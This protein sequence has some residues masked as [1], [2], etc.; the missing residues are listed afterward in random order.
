MFKAFYYSFPVQLFLNNL[1]KNQILLLFWVLLFAVVTE[2]FGNVLGVPY[3]FLDPEYMN[4]VDFWSFFIVGISLGV[5][6]MGFH[7]TCYILDGPK[8]NFLGTLRRPFT[9]FTINNSIIPIAFLITYIIAIINFQIE[10]EFVTFDLLIEKISGLIAGFLVM[11]VFL[12]AYF[13]FTNKD[14]FKILAANVDKSLKKVKVTRVNVMQRLDSAKKKSIRVDNFIDHNFQIR[15]NRGDLKFYNK[16]EIVKVFD[17]N[18][19]NSVIIEFLLFALI[20]SLGIFREQALFQIPAAASSILLLAFIIMFTGAISFWV[21]GWTITAVIALVFFINF[22][23]QSDYFNRTFEAY[24]LNY[25]TVKSIYTVKELQAIN[26]PEVFERD[27]ESTIEILNNW[28]NN[29]PEDKKPKMILIGTSGGGQRAALWTMRTLQFADSASNGSLLNNTILISGASGGLIGAAYYRELV[30]RKKQGE[31]IDLTHSKYLDN[32]ARDNLN[33]IIF[34]LLVND[35]FIRYQNFEFNGR[36]YAKDRGYAF[37][38]QLNK[39]TEFYL[40]KKLGDYKEPERQGL[41]PM[42][43]LAPNIIND[44]RKLY[45]S[46]QNTSYMNMAV[47]DQ[48]SNISPKIKAIDFSRYFQAQGAENLRFISALRMSATFPYVTPNIALPSEPKMQIM[49]AGIADNFGI[50]DAVRFL[51][52]FKDWINENTSGVIMISIRDSEKEQPIEKIP[53]KSLFEKI[54]NPIRSLYINFDNIQ[55]IN[56]DNLLEYADALTN[57]NIT[58]IN[59]E[60]IPKDIPEPTKSERGSSD[61]VIEREIERASLSW[62]LTGLEKNN[63]KRSIY[64]VNN[65]TALRRLLKE[66]EE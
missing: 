29:F 63:I 1:K 10:N 45:I 11:L 55:D 8:Y 33:P 57:Y 39:N 28:R 31:D 9:N 44:G 56:N 24:G 3:L 30:L 35:L 50:S 27:R 64:N 18:H 7:I 34:S 52:I 53:E 6:S 46:P 19:L 51:Y 2:N 49:D 5:F 32:I 12:Y 65:L 66:L 42:L 4:R 15:K 22:L 20:F 62:H 26:T 13:K 21:R 37:E 41:I 40:E 47:P 23:F 61:N 58:R 59:F 54:F 38:Q 43:F 25:D 17:Q 48:K 16:S 60:Y 36:F 14:I